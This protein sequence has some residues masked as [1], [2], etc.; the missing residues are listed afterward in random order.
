MNDMSR[1]WRFPTPRRDRSLG[2]AIARGFIGRC[3]ACGRGPLFRSYLK[4][5]NTCKVCGEDLS[6]QRADDAPAYLTLLIVAHGVGAGILLSDEIWPNS[7]LLWVAAFWLIV[8]VVASLLILPRAKGAIVGK[9]WALC[10]HGFGSD[11]D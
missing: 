7:S 11:G 1:V 6:H 9:Q 8:T 4:V 3:P 2:Q 5:V 10:M